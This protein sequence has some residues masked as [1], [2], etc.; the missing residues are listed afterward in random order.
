[1]YRVVERKM[2]KLREQGVDVVVLE[3][4][5][6]IEARWTSLVDKIWVTT[7]SEATV[8]KRLQSKNF[9]PVQALARMRSQLPS[10]E[11]AKWADVIINTDC[12]LSQLRSVVKEL[13]SE[14]QRERG[15]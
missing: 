1:M 9:T 6:L 10:A 8:L 15:Q 4:P 13:W 5:L 2:G 12:E 7:A 11:R 14:L 3:A